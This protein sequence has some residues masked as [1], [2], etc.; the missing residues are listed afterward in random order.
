MMDE[1]L[2]CGHAPTD[3]GLCY[4]NG[5]RMTTGYAT[6]RDGRRLCYSCADDMQRSELATADTYGAYV[7]SDGRR[8]TTWSGG[9][10]ARVTSHSIGRAGSGGQMHYWRAVTPD[11]AEFYGRN[12]GEG[13]CIT[14]RRA[15]RVA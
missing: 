13:M 5:Q 10:L 14:I 15:R 4:A 7:S 12:A 9:P 2:D 8:I 6:T 3:D 11:G 1:V